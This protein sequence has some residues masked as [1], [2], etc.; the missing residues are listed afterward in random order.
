MALARQHAATD[1]LP[2]T[3]RLRGGILMAVDSEELVGMF[4]DALREH[5]IAGH[6]CVR[7]DGDRLCPVLGDAPELVTDRRGA[8]VIEVDAI[9]GTSALMLFGRPSRSL[10]A[11]EIARVRGYAELYAA[12]AFALQEMEDDVETG[13]GLTLRERF[14][15]GRRL[16]GL[17]PI[18]IADEAGLSVEIV[19]ASLDSAVARLEVS[20]PAAAIAL[21]ARRGWLAIT[22]LQNCS[23]TSGNLTYKAIESG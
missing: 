14:V 11:A 22:D 12:R 15:L 17:A 20:T 2:A 4:A 10:T 3:A 19:S 7:A 9:D 21:A 6:F 18:D 23:S 1:F 8:L 5:G 16:A 13:C